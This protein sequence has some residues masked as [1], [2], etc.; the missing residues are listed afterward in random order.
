MKRILFTLILAFLTTGLAEARHITPNEKQA[1]E[2]FNHAYALVMG[3]QGCQLSYDVNIV[4]IYKTTGTI[5]YKGKK[6]KFIESRYASWNNGSIFYKVD[7]KKRTVEL[8]NPNSPKRDKYA[9]KFTFSPGSY[10]Y[11]ISLEGGAYVIR[12]DALKDAKS[13]IKH[14][15]VYLDKQTRYPLGVKV[16]VAFFWT[17]VKISHF[18]PGG[19]NDAVF[20][21]PR[22][23][24]AGYKFTDK[25]NE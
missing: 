1:R 19:I 20:E 9:S 7:K 11:H 23:Q 5:W 13:S 8:Y 6:S 4:G 15:K 24:F 25:R 18:K 14:A 12:M 3:K 22:S 2:M 16:K 17:T 21:F 10:E